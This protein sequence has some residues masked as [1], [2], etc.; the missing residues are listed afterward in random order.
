MNTPLAPVGGRIGGT[1]VQ[2]SQPQQ[3]NE[4]QMTGFEVKVTPN[5][6][7][8]HFDLI[9]TSSNKSPVILKIADLSGRSVAGE[10]K[11]SPNSFVRLGQSWNAGTYFIEVMQGNQKKVVKVVKIKR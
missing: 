5:P 8:S 10:Q 4:T 2:A 3:T 11:I 9:V 1:T 6:T 7:S